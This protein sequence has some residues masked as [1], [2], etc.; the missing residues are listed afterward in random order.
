MTDR[1][2]VAQ[3]DA[4]HQ[5]ATTVYDGFISV[6]GLGFQVAAFDVLLWMV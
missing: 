6:F 1:N 4:I 3:P 2:A 5:P